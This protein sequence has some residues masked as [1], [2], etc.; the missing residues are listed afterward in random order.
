MAVRLLRQPRLVVPAI[1]LLSLSAIPSAVQAQW[2]R[3][4][5]LTGEDIV[6]FTAI[7]GNLF[8]AGYEHGAYRSTD[9][10]ANWFQVGLGGVSLY[11]LATSGTKLI[12]GRMSDGIYL[13]AD[14]GANWVQMNAGLTNRQITSISV[15]GTTFLAGTSTGVFQS[16]DAGTSWSQI[17][18]D[19]ANTE[20]NAYAFSGTGVYAGTERGVFLSTNNGSAWTAVNSGLTNTH[21]NALAISG[22]NVF[23]GTGGGVFLSTN[24]GSSWTQDTA[25]LGSNPIHAFALFE[26]TLFAGTSASG[27]Y[28]SR[29]GGACWTQV[30]SGL[31]TEGGITVVGAL[32]V[33]NSFLFAGV[34]GGIWRRPLSEL[35]SAQPLVGE[36]PSEP[37]LFQNYPNPSNP[38]TRINYSLSKAGHVQLRM[39]DPLWRIVTALVDRKENP[40][41]H[42]VTWSGG[43]GGRRIS[44]GVYFYQLSVDGTAPFIC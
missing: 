11:V 27:I 10:G 41:E 40:G 31:S 3:T 14:G 7:G 44:S 34:D 28:V 6:S 37:K 19:F 39:L 25:G 9:G 20:V 33:S 2:V 35:T 42:S 30:N 36:L 29:N 23:A 18:N 12:A 16:T 1:A 13:S 26:A 38:S 24:N 21:V 22:A 17:Q 8:A 32:H 4:N 15:N 43:G 5:G